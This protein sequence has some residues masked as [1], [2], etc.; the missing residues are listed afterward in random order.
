MTE[1]GILVGEAPTSK[2]KN[3]HLRLG[4][5]AGTHRRRRRLDSPME[6]VSIL[7]HYV[8]AIPYKMVLGLLFK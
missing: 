1:P 2:R 4:G 6:M 5:G 7:E 8:Q 3:R